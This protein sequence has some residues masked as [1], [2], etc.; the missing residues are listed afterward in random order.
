MSKYQFIFVGDSGLRI[1]VEHDDSADPKL[2]H[3]IAAFVHFLEG[4]S[5]THASVAK[6]I[7]HELTG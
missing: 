2:D 1:T 4:V 5:F 3:V 7:D 6:F